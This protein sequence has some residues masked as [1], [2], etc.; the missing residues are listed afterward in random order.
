MRYVPGAGA[1]SLYARERAL[2]AILH[3]SA[4]EGWHAG[5]EE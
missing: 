5:A 2:M 1:W 4:E 3:A